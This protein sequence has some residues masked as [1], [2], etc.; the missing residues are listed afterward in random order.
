MCLKRYELDP[1]RFLSAVSLA[2]Q[3]DLKKTKV[4]LDRLNDIYMLLMVEKGTYYRRNRSIYLLI[5]KS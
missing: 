3:P 4:R 2:C 1:A 5:C